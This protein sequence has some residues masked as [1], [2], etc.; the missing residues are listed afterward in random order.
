[1]QPISQTILAGGTAALSIAASG[2]PTP[3]YQWQVSTNGGSTWTSLTDT[4][5]YSG[6]TAGT[7]TIAGATT[8]INGYQYKCLA[9]NLVQSNVA[10]N[11]ATLT[12]NKATPV[13]NWTTPAAITYPSALSSTQLNATANVP[14]TFVYTPTA[15]T[16]LAAGSQTLSVTF[17]PTDSTDYTSATMTQMVTVTGT[18]DQA[19]L[20]QLFLDVLG[21]PID[22]GALTAYQAALAGGESRSAVLGGLLTST[23]YANRQV[24]PAI[25]L[26]YAALARCPDYVGLQ[27]WSNA[28]SAGVLTLTSAA[29]QFAASA[30]FTLKYGSLDNTGYVQQLYRNVLGREADP[31]GLA[32]WV[33]QLNAGSSR[34]TILVGFSESS[35]FQ[36]DMASQVEII[37]LYDLLLQRMP[38]TSELQS[39]QGFLL[40]YDQTDTLFAQGYPSG[41]ADSDY[42]SLV[43]QGFLRRAADS[44]ALSTFGSALTAGTVTHGS[45]VNTLLTSA[46]FNQ[47]VA[48]VSRLYMAAFRRVPDSGGLDNWVAYVRAGNTL[49]SAADA[50]V[51][52]QEFQLTYGSLNDTQ[53]VTLLYENV[54]GREPD[55][56]GLATWTGDL[57]S[58]WTRGQVLIGFSESQE[59]IALFAPTVRTF[60]H[61]FTF[62]NA[63]PAQADLDYW[64]NYL[65][66]L[67]DQMRATML[68][69]P[70][71][72]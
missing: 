2:T 66:T 1:L 50:F 6:T 71:S 24:E 61:Y 13:I 19:F 10:S 18:S 54:L 43:F 28:L 11:A 56:T 12:V 62:L 4:A 51:A 67:D 33:G 30:E 29:D 25:R 55:P 40:G 57:G 70:T 26:Y 39:W 22:S 8:A 21:R 17:T 64:K 58:G 36:A 72:A 48:P 69:D 15:E 9:S 68:A 65:V 38:T 31:A 46:E 41:M 42:V 59:G 60:L 45:L 14:G 7:L 52:S 53:Y 63:T 32:D 37:R 5:P 49:Q 44:G 23:E 47:L 27:N 20:Q 35:E 16:V 34:G 3:T